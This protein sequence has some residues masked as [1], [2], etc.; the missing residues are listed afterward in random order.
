MEDGA[1]RIGVMVLR[2]DDLLLGVGAADG[3]AVAVAALDDLAGADALDPGDLV[4]M[5]LVGGAQDLTGVGAGGAE[6]PLVVHAGDDV[7]ELAVAVFLS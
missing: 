3:R 2:E 7:R 6:E 1:L 5:L 4:G